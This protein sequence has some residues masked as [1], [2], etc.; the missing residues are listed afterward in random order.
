MYLKFCQWHLGHAEVTAALSVFTFPAQVFGDLLPHHP[1]FTFAQRTRNFKEGTHVQVVL[2]GSTQVS[3]RQEEPQPL[4][5]RCSQG[6]AGAASVPGSPE[7]GCGSE[8]SEP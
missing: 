5:N 7:L 3:T 6:S 2:Q 8:P 4:I 1:L